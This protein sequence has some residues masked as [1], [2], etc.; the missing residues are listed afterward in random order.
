MLRNGDVEV[1]ADREEWRVRW[2]SAPDFNGADGGAI[3]SENSG[4]SAE[5]ACIAR[6]I[7]AAV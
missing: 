4:L 5:T 3:V 1:S 2:S 6:K 7:S